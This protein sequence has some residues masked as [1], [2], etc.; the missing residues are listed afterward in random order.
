MAFRPPELANP[1]TRDEV[2]KKRLAACSPMFRP[3]MERAYSG[4]ASPRKAIRAMCLE[5]TGYDRAVI[6]G[7]TGYSCPLWAY[8]PFKNEGGA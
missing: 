4:E 7:C 5:C 8:R 1:V 2:V 6:R 3:V